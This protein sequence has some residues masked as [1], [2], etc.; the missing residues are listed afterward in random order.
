MYR[1][2]AVLGIVTGG[3]LLLSSGAH[4]ILGW[5]ALGAELSEAAL[6]AELMTSVKIGWQFGGVAMFGFGCVTILLFT[7]LLRKRRVSLQPALIIG[8]LYSV[9]A[10]WALVSSNADP[11]FLIF[12]I[13]GITLIACS[14]PQGASQ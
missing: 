14:W 3:F 9:F 5:K 11:F 8:L 7:A 13:P 6:P 1:F 12:L 4:S 10:T 2:R